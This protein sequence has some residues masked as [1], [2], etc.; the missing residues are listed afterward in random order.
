[1]IKKSLIE[2]IFEASSIERWNDHIRPS[3]GFTE[4]DKQAHK[5]QYAYVLGNLA[6]GIDKRKLIEGGIFEFLHRLVLT[7]IKPPVFHQLTEEKGAQINKWVLDMVKN[8][9]EPL[10]EG[11]MEKF[12]EYLLNPEYAKEEKK[13]LEAAH[14]LATKWEFDI[15]YGMCTT[16]YG[17]EDTKLEIMKKIES[18]ND[19]DFFRKY[20]DDKNLEAFTNLIGELRFQQRWSRCPRIPATSVMGHTIIV[21]I[22]AYFCSLEM[23]AGD[24]RTVNNFFGGLFHDMPEVLTRDIVS[25]VKRSVEGLDE[26]IKEI[27]DNQMRKTIYPL[28]PAEWHKDVDYYTNDEF[29]SKIRLEG[30]TEFTTTEEISAKYNDD[31]FD[32]IDGEILKG[33]DEFG[34]Y[35]E[36]YFS[37]ITGV[38]S[39][40][41]RDANRTLYEKYKNKILGGIDF[42]LLFDYFK[43]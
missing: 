33:C 25:P 36:T 34:A 11:F 10:P 23:G 38:T 30:K 20:R 3:R 18:F 27:E 26:L 16:Y 22:M 43:I 41:L 29:R 13:V 40:T 17:I 1:M 5:M 12:S 4:L 21:A 35:I 31:K 39:H 42:G 7:D 8:D 37:H 24:R 6:E 15:I 2:F 14:Y 28:L 32:A 19:C 9:I